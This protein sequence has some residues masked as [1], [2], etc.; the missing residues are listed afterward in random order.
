MIRKLKPHK[1]YKKQGCRCCE[2]DNIS[3]S[4]NYTLREV[5]NLEASWGNRLTNLNLNFM[6]AISWQTWIITAN[7]FMMEILIPHKN[8]RRSKTY[9][10]RPNHSDCKRCRNIAIPERLYFELVIITL[11]I[12]LWTQLS[13]VVK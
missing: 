4:V 2:S 11:M 10:F 7:Q 6:S 3:C 9:H 8:R 12:N 5:L 1:P 13:L